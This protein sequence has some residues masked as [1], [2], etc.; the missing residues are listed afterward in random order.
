M[1]GSFIGTGIVVALLGLAGGCNQD[2]VSFY[3]VGNI[4]PEEMEATC[5]LNPSGQLLTRGR[6]NT[7]VNLGEPYVV[8][9]LYS[10]QLRARRGPVAANPNAV[11]ITEAEVTL[12]DE[13]G[14]ALDFGGLPN[15]FTVRTGSTFVPASADGTTPG[16]SVGEVPAIPNVYQSALGTSGT[17]IAAIKVFGETTGDTDIETEEWLWPIDLCGGDC[18]F[19]CPA[20]MAGGGG[21]CTPG[22]DVVTEA[23]CA[24]AGA[25]TC[26]AELS[27]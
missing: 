11:H 4:I 15:P 9:P 5:S 17:V 18:L 20:S 26:P 27:L 1:R 3:I 19:A 6:Y 22:Q 12:R 23:A 7:Q 21:G 14:Q 2:N 25:G 10:N 24:C 8:F 16:Q 13:A